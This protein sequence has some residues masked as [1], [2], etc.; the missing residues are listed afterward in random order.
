MKNLFLCKINSYLI[1]LFPWALITGPFLPDLIV[2]LSG[3]LLIFHVFLNRQFVL[4]KSKF[5]YFFLIFYLYFLI[6]SFYSQ[7][8]FLSLNSSL[9]HFR[10]V[11]F[12]FAIKYCFENEKNFILK[13]TYSGLLAILIVSLDGYL[14]YFT[15]TNTFNLEKFHNYRVSGFFGDELIMG[16]YLSRL[17]PIFIGLYFYINNNLNF[18]KLVPIFFL[19]IIVDVLIFIAAERTSIFYLFLFSLI[20]IFCSNNFKVFRLITFLIS[21]L[22]MN[23]LLFTNPVHKTRIIDQT[24]NQMGI[25]E[26]SKIKIFTE[27]HESI[28]TS[29]FK[30]FKDNPLFG[31]GPNMF[32]KLCNDDKFVSSQSCSTHPHN[33]YLEF[34]AEGGV[35][36]FMPFFVIFCF[37]CYLILRQIAYIWIPN[38]KIKIKFEDHQTFL[39]IAVI[40]TLW[41]LAPTPSFFTNNWVGGIYYLPIGFLISRK[42]SSKIN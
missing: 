35:I 10:Y 31:Q 32:R 29:A 2:C 42:F 8:L 7:D 15:G 6:R 26:G 17:L 9:F 28:Y 12:V 39:I 38:L 21:I 18:K 25:G 40:I 14:Q 33:I 36:L 13:F 3:F 20:I 4:F 11:F 22:I 23:I 27:T 37:L 41:P 5:L 34:L 1:I 30:M 24:I 16:S 19:I